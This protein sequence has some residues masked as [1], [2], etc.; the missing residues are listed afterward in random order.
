MNI[1]IKFRIKEI[2]TEKGISIRQLAEMT[3]MS[4][5]YLSELENGHYMPS[6][7]VLCKIAVALDVKPEKLYSYK[8]EK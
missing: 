8:T 5:S 2:R 6:I 1:I 4:K 3:D 7:F